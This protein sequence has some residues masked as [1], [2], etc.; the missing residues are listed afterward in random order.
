VILLYIVIRRSRA[1]RD[2]R[3]IDDI[4]DDYFDYS[5]IIRKSARLVNV[6]SRGESLFRGFCSIR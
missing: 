3:Y 1:G 4:T 6:L 2:G 5:E